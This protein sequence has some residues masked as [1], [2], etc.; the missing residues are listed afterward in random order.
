M[1][2]LLSA[3]A[4]GMGRR[5]AEIGPVAERQLLV[6]PRESGHGDGHD[7]PESFRHCIDAPI[8]K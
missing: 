5:T 2:S 7:W 3:L 6:G 1:S 8:E 4:I